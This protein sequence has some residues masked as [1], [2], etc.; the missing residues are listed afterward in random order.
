MSQI[1]IDVSEDPEAMQVPS[2]WNLT[3][4]TPPLWSVKARIK[5]FDVTS[6][7]LTWRSSDPEQISR[8][9][10]ENSADLIQF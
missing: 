5:A 2:G 7:S 3:E 1:L 4:L 6:Q 8:V 10:G 9:S